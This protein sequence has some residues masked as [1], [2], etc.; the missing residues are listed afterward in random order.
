VASDRTSKRPFP[1]W[2]GVAVFVTVVVAIAIVLL[3]QRIPHAKR[4]IIQPPPHTT[5]IT[6]TTTR[7]PT[8]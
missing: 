7:T 3:A 8:G 1:R 6:I 5:V 4:P 2:T